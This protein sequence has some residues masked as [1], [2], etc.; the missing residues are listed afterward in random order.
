L[1]AAIGRDSHPP[2]CEPFAA[3]PLSDCMMQGSGCEAHDQGIR[4]CY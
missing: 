2:D 1:G 3:A 4:C